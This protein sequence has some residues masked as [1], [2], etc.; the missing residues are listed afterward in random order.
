MAAA[1]AVVASIYLMESPQ[2]P[3]RQRGAGICGLYVEKK[4]SIS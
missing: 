4:H 1:A 3:A 2:I